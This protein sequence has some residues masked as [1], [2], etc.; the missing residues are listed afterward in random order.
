M[1]SAGVLV[2]YHQR[3]DNKSA[4]K[5]EVRFFTSIIRLFFENIQISR[6][7]RVIYVLKLARINQTSPR[8]MY[9]WQLI[10]VMKT[11]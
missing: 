9:S 2:D 8:I 3:G 5:A 11:N 4:K 10:T 6:L 7:C 1:F